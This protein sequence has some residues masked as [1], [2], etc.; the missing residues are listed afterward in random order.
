MLVEHREG[1]LSVAPKSFSLALCRQDL[2]AQRAPRSHVYGCATR[3][4]CRWQCRQKTGYIHSQLPE[5]QRSADRSVDSA[6]KCV[7]KS[8]GSAGKSA[9]SAGKSAG[10]AGKSAGSAGKSVDSAGKSVGKIRG[11]IHCVNA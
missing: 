8:A 7:G 5:N 11:Y 2:L 6:D 1:E 3:R 9:D 4:L 10:S